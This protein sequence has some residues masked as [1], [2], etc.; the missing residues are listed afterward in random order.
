M[1]SGSEL[2]TG[3]TSLLWIF[4]DN[5]CLLPVIHQ[6]TIS[7]RPTCDDKAKI[8]WH[9]SIKQGAECIL[10]VIKF[11][12]YFLTKMYVLKNVMVLN[13]M[14]LHVYCHSCHLSEQNL[15]N[16]LMQLKL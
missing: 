2:C 14:C 10:K 1:L 15:Y 12:T 16:T 3:C 13:H 6:S 5:N 9:S 8:L 4:D 7:I 11:L